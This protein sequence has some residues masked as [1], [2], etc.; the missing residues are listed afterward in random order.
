MG[1]GGDFITKENNGY[2]VFYE[3]S[4]DQLGKRVVVRG[5]GGSPWDLTLYCLRRVRSLEYKLL[6]IDE[7]ESRS[8]A[9]L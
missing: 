1:G 3:I 9:D 4:T 7:R 5:G 6:L 8:C 2:V